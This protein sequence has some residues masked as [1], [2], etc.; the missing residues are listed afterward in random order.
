M[1]YKFT[2]SLLSLCFF[3][4]AAT[5]ISAQEKAS[6]KGQISLTNN[7]TADNVSVTLKGTK[8]GTNT[9][10]NGFYEIKNLKPGSY[11]IKVSAVGYSSKEK[12]ISLNAGDEIVEDFTIS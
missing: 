5:S 6:V 1:K 9:D 4:F 12:S 8:I 2:I 10:S 7:Q 3:L 11:V